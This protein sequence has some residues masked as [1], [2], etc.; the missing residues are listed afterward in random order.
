[1]VSQKYKHAVISCGLVAIAFLLSAQI[2]DKPLHF[3]LWLCD[4]RLLVGTTPLL[5]V[6]GVRFQGEPAPGAPQTHT[7]PSQRALVL[8]WACATGE[9]TRHVFEPQHS[10]Q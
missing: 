8:H 1:M 5:Y 6:P 9:S 4:I 7:G 3:L 2:I 10:A